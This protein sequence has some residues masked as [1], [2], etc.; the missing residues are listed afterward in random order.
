MGKIVN[1]PGSYLKPFRSICY[2][3]GRLQVAVLLLRAAISCP[4]VCPKSGLDWLE[5]CTKS[6]L[7]RVQNRSCYIDLLWGF[8]ADQSERNTKT[9]GQL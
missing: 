7:L 6:L 3:K 4:A 1:L 9:A 8:L 2:S 5:S